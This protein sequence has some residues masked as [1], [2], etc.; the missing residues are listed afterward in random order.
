MPLSNRRI[1]AL[2]FQTALFCVYFQSPRCITY[3]IVIAHAMYFCFEVR[4][5]ATDQRLIWLVLARFYLDASIGC[6]G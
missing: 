3:D 4:V 2:P 6:H 1:N 5:T